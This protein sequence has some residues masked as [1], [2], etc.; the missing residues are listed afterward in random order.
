[1][2]TPE[3]LFLTRF[4]VANGRI[5]AFSQRKTDPFHDKIMDFA[6]LLKG[7]LAQRFVNRIG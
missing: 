6:A 4:E 5:S 7:D 1:M 2:L 3:S